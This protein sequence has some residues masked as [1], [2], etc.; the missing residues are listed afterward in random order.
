MFFGLRNTNRL[1][2]GGMSNCAIINYSS[3]KQTS[4]VE[5]TSEVRAHLIIKNTLDKSDSCDTAK[6]SPTSHKSR[7]NKVLA[8]VNRK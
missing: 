1:T 4:D 5:K 3:Q 2:K 6:K 7:E 8:L